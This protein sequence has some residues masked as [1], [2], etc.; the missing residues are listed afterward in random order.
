MVEALIGSIIAVIATGALAM[1]AEVFTKTQAG[2]YPESDNQISLTSY[3]K[4]VLDVVTSARG[5]SKSVEKSE[6]NDLK[7]WLQE[8]W[9]EGL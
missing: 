4:E 6:Q 8:R 2:P 7:S 5:R 9:K 3:E 1:M